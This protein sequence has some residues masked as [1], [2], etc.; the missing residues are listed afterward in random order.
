MS[1]ANHFESGL[2]T[3]I[4]TVVALE[5]IPHYLSDSAE[6]IDSALPHITI[7]GG[8]V[9]HVAGRYYTATARITL[10][11]P[12]LPTAIDGLS[13]YLSTHR[14]YTDSLHSFLADPISLAIAFNS[15]FVQLAG[16]FFQSI[17]NEAVENRWTT[18]IDLK[19]GIA[20]LS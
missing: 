18:T 2:S 20:T 11:S 5:D 14:A 3:A 9:E 19:C 12:A 8:Q 10:I 6:I 13:L 1:I 17:T 15:S 16:S 7:S 4:N